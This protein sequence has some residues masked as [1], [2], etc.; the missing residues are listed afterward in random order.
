M[1]GVPV[2]EEGD[3]A[4]KE[5]KLEVKDTRRESRDKSKGKSEFRHSIM[6]LSVF[7]FI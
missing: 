1:K 7:R 2:E 4:E 6:Y 3:I 5:V